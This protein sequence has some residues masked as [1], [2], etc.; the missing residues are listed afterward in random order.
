MKGKM[1]VK[2][3]L[4]FSLVVALVCSS[5]YLAIANQPGTNIAQAAQTN[6]IT[7]PGF[8]TGSLSPWTEWHPTGQAAYY[9]IDGTD[10]HS[11][12]KKLYFYA[13]SAFQESAH[14]VVSVPNGTYTLRAWVKVT[15]GGSQPYTARMEAS[16]N[17]TNPLYTNMT[18]DGTWKHYTCNFYVS[19]GTID[20]GFYLNS[21]GSTSMQI[22][23]VELYNEPTSTIYQAESA[24]LSGGAKTNT[25]HSNYTGTGFV[26]GYT[27]QGATATFT[28]N[29]A[30]K[31]S[32]MTTLRYCNSTGS[33]K[34]VSIYLNGQK[35]RQI[36]LANLTD[37]NTWGDEVEILD[38]NA[39]NN[40]IAY[41]YDSGDSGNVNLDFVRILPIPANKLVTVYYKKGY[42][43]PNIHYHLVDGPWTTSPGIKMYDSEVTGY[44]KMPIYLDFAT[45]VEG[46]FNDGGSNWDNNGAMN[47][48]FAPGT[49]TVEYGVTAPCAPVL[50]TLNSQPTGTLFDFY[51]SAYYSKTDNAYQYKVTYD[52]SQVD[53][54]DLSNETANRETAP[55]TIRG[56]NVS[57]N[58]VVGGLIRYTTNEILPTG[59]KWSGATT[60]TTFKTRVT[61]AINL[62][63]NLEYTN[64]SFPMLAGGRAHSVYLRADG[65][66]YAW[67]D[68]WCG[69]LGDGT[70]QVRTRP[71]RVQ[72]I[73]N[74]RTISSG[75]DH[76]IALA[77]D[78]S[79]WTWGANYSGQI[80]D[81][82][83]AHK[84]L[85]V[86]LTS[87]GNSIVSV[88]AGRDFTAAVKNDGTLWVWGNTNNFGVTNTNVPV[89]VPNLTGIVSVACGAQNIAIIKADGSVW[90]WGN[91]DYGQIGDGTYAA[92]TSPVKVA[93]DTGFTQAISVSVG[94]NHVIAIAPDGSLW[95]WGMNQKGQLGNGNYNQQTKPVKSTGISSVRAVSA[96]Y[97]YTIALKTDG[98]VWTFGCNDRGELGIGS[99]TPNMT[100]TPTQTTLTG[101]TNI[102]AGYN[103]GLALKNDSNIWTWGVDDYGQLGN[104]YMGSQY[105]S[106]APIL[107]IHPSDLVGFSG[108][109]FASTSM[110]A[111]LDPSMVQ[112]QL[113]FT[114]NQSTTKI[115]TRAINLS[116]DSIRDLY[117]GKYLC[118]DYDTKNSEYV[119]EVPKNEQ[120]IPWVDVVPYDIAATYKVVQANTFDDKAEITVTSGDGTQKKIYVSFTKK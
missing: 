23:D 36:S 39:G 97:Y 31:G 2:K 99:S 55:G 19:N 54:I 53:L 74:I 14:Q 6:L 118:T 7:N 9:G 82:T 119:L 16:S 109:Y 110:D 25:N 4:I 32:Y 68:N 78:G 79:V 13:T 17:G 61:G 116:D 41:K 33:T 11:G 83:L 111:I 107:A 52:P 34:T 64:T 87:L 114:Q 18:V 86:Q 45:G 1:Q 12:T 101:V 38:L 51:P 95:G 80:G 48:Y 27:A 3:V 10:V 28:V 62:Q 43:S 26:D 50:T 93:S 94:E 67:G 40:T 100:Y 106:F 60:G 30:S 73:S 120:I 71:V 84:Y 90:V 72:N 98:T 58:Q 115:K 89:Q 24:S 8:E 57:A 59:K 56:T 117:V 20:V 92:K 47:Y 44:S 88:G 46:V 22:D 63:L 113:S 35:L 112:S 70:D 104:G 102:G 76:N 96:G 29:A 21:P 66:V 49:S 103:H 85:P 65:N 108:I 91:N 77:R 37:W 105:N 69:Q 42:S 5:L 81:G 15:A 75:K